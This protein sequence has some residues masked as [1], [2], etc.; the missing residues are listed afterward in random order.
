MTILERELRPVNPHFSTKRH[1]LC[2]A[3]VI[4]LV[5]Q[6][7]MNALD[8]V[9]D[10]PESTFIDGVDITNLDG[11]VN[12]CE[13]NVPS[14]ISLG[15]VVQRLREVVRAILG[16]TMQENKYFSYSRQ[17]NMPNTRRIP[18][19]YPNKWSSTYKMLHECLEK[20]IVINVMMSSAF[21]KPTLLD[22]E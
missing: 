5:M 9:E 4:N 3:H 13:M 11:V 8:V 1:V 12:G 20:R 17:S 19:D 16:S 18:L 7:G 10:K 14:D 6:A 15:D 21:R 2:M 22:A